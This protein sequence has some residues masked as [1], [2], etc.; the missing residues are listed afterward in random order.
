MA[1][2]KQVPSTTMLVLLAVLGGGSTNIASR[3][4]GPTER[5]DPWTGTQAN[6]AHSRLASTERVNYLQLRLEALEKKINM[7]EHLSRTSK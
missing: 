4:L 5:P 2:E 7:Y 3:A 6:A 1:D